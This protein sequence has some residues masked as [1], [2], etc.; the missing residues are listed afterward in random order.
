MKKWMASSMSVLIAGV[1]S[2]A[3]LAQHAPEQEQLGNVRFPVSCSAEAQQKFHRA[4]A[5]YHSFSWTRVRPAF[6]E[7]TQ[8]D[9][10]CGMA[11]W[12]L[13]MVAADNPFG[14][15]QSVQLKEGEEAIQKAQ[16]VGASTPR[17]RDYI[18]ALAL[19][20]KDHATV[21]HRQRAL[22]YEQAMEQLADR[23][24]DDV[25]ANILHADAVR[26]VVA[27]ERAAI[28]VA[29]DCLCTWSGLADRWAP[30]G[31]PCVLG[32]ALDMHASHGGPAQH[33]TSAAHTSAGR[34]R[35]GRRPT[36]TGI[37]PRGGPPGTWGGGGG[38]A[39]VNARPC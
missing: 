8:V 23:Y 5:L 29:V 11:W 4:M 36:P 39:G 27:P 22:A 19:L 17:E 15:P 16:A 28:V 35:G 37:P 2:S 10:Q 6:T 18:A 26:T 14:W 21:P 38:R 25:E 9:A 12:G 24:P 34:R 7:I 20:Y 33:D 13:A 32:Q 3:V 1:F 31:L 30:A